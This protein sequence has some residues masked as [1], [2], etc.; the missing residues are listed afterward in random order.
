MQKNFILVCEKDNK[1][2]LINCC[3]K[4]KLLDNIVNNTCNLLDEI[5]KGNIDVDYIDVYI[6]SEFKNRYVPEY[7][8]VTDDLIEIYSNLTQLIINKE[9]TNE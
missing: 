8:K 3:A 1:K 4:E 6:N 5:K 2:T 9:E 7:K